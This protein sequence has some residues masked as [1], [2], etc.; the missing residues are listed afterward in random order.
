MTK[1]LNNAGASLI[2]EST[3]RT[4]TD[5]L[6]LERGIGAYQAAV[7]SRSLTEEF[8]ADSARLINASSS[9]EIAF[10]DSASRGWNMA[11]RGL[12][13]H[14][15]DKILTLS[16]EFGTNLITLVDYARRNGGIV[17]VIP[18]DISGK[19]SLD[20]I[21]DGL[22]D[23]ARIVAISHAAAQG[24]IVN[25]VEA[26][27][28]LCRKYGSIYIVDGCQAVGQFDVDVQE[29]Q[30]DAYITTGRKWLRGPRGTG[31]LYV[32][33]GSPIHSSQLD[34]A[35]ADLVIDRNNNI[36][37]IQIRSDARQFEL[38]ERTIACMLGLGNAV[39]E[40]LNG[41]RK[42][43]HAQIQHLA[44]RLRTSVVS[45]S[46]LQLIGEAESMSGIVAFYVNDPQIEERVNRNIGDSF[47]ISSMSDWDCPLHFPRNGAQ[48]IFRFSPHYYTEEL[49]V[50][51]ACALITN[52]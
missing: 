34:L 10:M 30:C 50:A 35:S 11:V 31:F 18:C 13:L 1:Y 41:D 46:A 49:I 39:K 32:K 25:P 38:W 52:L 51:E 28:E 3:Y 7:K 23:G 44:N 21:E 14:A 36:V 17:H 24:S 22:K 19:F 2:S 6:E 27:G 29:M 42:W 9:S 26:I 48:K 15:G 33:S 8:Y 5:H 43:M 37:D 16:S 20:K 47:T 40:Y 4:I 12:D 45:N